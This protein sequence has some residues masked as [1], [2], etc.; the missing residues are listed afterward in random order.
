MQ[1]ETFT[2]DWTDAQVQKKSP[3][4]KG[5]QGKR[6]HFRKT[7]NGLGDNGEHSPDVH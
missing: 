6:S 2:L 5:I 4:Y 7:S 1:L 3:A